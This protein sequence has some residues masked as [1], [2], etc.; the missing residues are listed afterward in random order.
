MKIKK[1]LV[2]TLVFIVSHALKAQNKYNSQLF[3]ATNTSK[4]TSNPGDENWDWRFDKPGVSNIVLTAYA[5]SED[6]YV[7]GN[8]TKAGTIDA[9]NIARYNGI[10]WQA[11]GS[12][13]GGPQDGVYAIKK[14]GNYLYACGTTGVERWNGVSWTTIGT[15]SGMVNNE[16]SAYAMDIDANGNVYVL[17]LFSQINGITVNGIAKWNGTSWSALGS[18]IGPFI[19]GVKTGSVVCDGTNVYISGYFSTVGGVAANS[20]AKWNGS[21]WS[22][23]DNGTNGTTFLSMQGTNLIA[24]GAFTTAGLVVANHVAMWNGIAWTVMGAG[25]NYEG[26]NVCVYNNEIYVAGLFD[27]SGTTPI[28]Y[29]AKW[30]GNT[31]I[32]AG[33]GFN[34]YTGLGLAKS[35]KYFVAY[36]GPG[37]VNNSNMGSIAQWNGTQWSTIG[38]GVNG[39]IYAMAAYNNKILIGGDFTE[40][41]GIKANRFAMW[42]GNKWD[43]LPNEFTNGSVNAIAIWNNEIY[44]GGNFNLNNNLSN[45]YLVKWNGTNWM[46][47]GN[48]VDYT[49]FALEQQGNKLYVGGEFTNSGGVSANKIA[50]WDGINWSSLGTGTNNTVKS[51][52]A[53]TAGNIYVGGV[54]TI[55][56]AT[57]VNRIAKWNGSAWSA[58][59]F[60]VNNIVN[61]VGIS[62]LGEVYIGGQF[63]I[64]VNGGLVNHFAKFNGTNWVNVGGSFP[65]ISNNVAN[66]I[67]VCGQM[68]VC[69]SLTNASGNTLNCVA[70]WDGSNWF[71]L[72]NGILF[73]NSIP[74]TYV[75][76]MASLNDDLYAGGI[77]STSGDKP[78]QNFAHYKI[79][80]YPEVN[81]TTTNNSI[82]AGD[83]ITSTA[84]AINSGASPT[85]QWK[86]NGNVVG[87]NSNTFTTA[88]LSNNSQ[89]SVTVITNPVCALPATISSN[90]VTIHVDS[91][92][93]PTINLVA[94]SFTV[95]NP[96]PFATYIWQTQQTAIWMDIFPLTIGTTFTFSTPGNYRARAVKGG[97]E[98]Y[99]NI[100]ATTAI[101]EIEIA[102]NFM[103]YPNPVKNEVTIEWI[104]V[105]INIKKV[106]IENMFG[107]CVFATILKD[108]NNQIKLNTATL[109]DGMYYVRI[110][111]DNGDFM[112]LKFIKQ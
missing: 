31:W 73:N 4:V 62:P 35:S 70:R 55:A 92:N 10:S 30:N 98:K 26:Y 36:G 51:I 105:N 74:Q 93:S 19:N 2:F 100:I 15:I 28:N 101:N 111:L 47:V 11:I 109:L 24:T 104:K 86:L 68:Y 58:M 106:A 96:D 27:H 102:S 94:N 34:I 8:F 25:F 75:N 57:T 46:P 87:N 71:N 84:T 7:G 66:I 103:V 44:A 80:G 85:F 43:T 38:N 83:T 37:T 48:D 81:I 52:K 40:V 1:L 97:C 53:D 56:G 3:N 39:N 67:F 61:S 16:L 60:G 110:T 29:I 41:G 12:G 59:A 72:G 90:I 32:D 50:S 63:D 112:V 82:C 22:P 54:F 20:V 95:T 65:T 79:D 108:G 91:L 13:I 9:I 42:D 33:T 23:L 49:V 107:Q 99:S 77:F 6:L 88:T 69:G 17:G 5:D 21:V 14:Q 89:I 64:A 78:A 76:A 18:G 45:N